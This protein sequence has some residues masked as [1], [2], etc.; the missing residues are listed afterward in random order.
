MITGGLHRLILSFYLGDSPIF[1]SR[2]AS[3]CLGGSA[4]SAD[5][6]IPAFHGGPEACPELV[7]GANRQT[8]GLTT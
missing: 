8:I 7:E 1:I 5:H 3:Q 6:V 2:D 4:Q